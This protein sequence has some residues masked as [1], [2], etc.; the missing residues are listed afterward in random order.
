LWESVFGV[1]RGGQRNQNDDS[2]DQEKNSAI[3]SQP[4]LGAT[5]SPLS[6]KASIVSPSV[7]TSGKKF[8]KKT[9]MAGRKKT[10]A[11][12]GG[13]ATSHETIASSTSQSEVTSNFSPESEREALYE[14]YNQLHTLAQV[15]TL[16]VF[17][18][19]PTHTFL[20]AIFRIFKNH[21]MLQL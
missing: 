19:I 13:R 4:T 3:P 18:S 8:T 2:V 10:D 15:R 17:H 9:A 7:S 21:L 5:N 11:T 1:G 12:A 6:T 14:A 20:V 16:M